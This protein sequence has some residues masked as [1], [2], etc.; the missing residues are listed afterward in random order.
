MTNQ[1]EKKIIK[2]IKLFQG[3]SVDAIAVMD[4]YEKEILLTRNCTYDI[5]NIFADPTLLDS[6]KLVFIAAI[7]PCLGFTQILSLNS[8]LLKMRYGF[9][10]SDAILFDSVS[11]MI[12]LPLNFFMP[13]I[14]EKV[15]RRPVILLNVFFNL[16]GTL[17]IFLTQFIFDLIGPNVITITLSGCFSLIYFLTAAMGIGIFGILLVTDLLPVGS[18]SAVSQIILVSGTIVSIITNFYFSFFDPI[19]GSFVHVPLIIFQLVFF[20]YFW[21]HLPETKQR[22]VNENFEKLRSIVN[23]CRTSRCPTLEVAKHEYGTFN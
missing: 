19:L 3:E 20:I 15:G 2:T 7:I 5:K 4:E 13:I 1:D 9:S 8:V 12:L 6:F 23:S 14:I 21:K 18:K 22:S 11:S 16:A 17:L 10:N